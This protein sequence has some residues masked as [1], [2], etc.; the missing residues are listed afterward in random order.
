[1][2]ATPGDH[3]WWLHKVTAQYIAQCAHFSLDKCMLIRYS[4]FGQGDIIT[5]SIPGAQEKAYQ[6]L[7]KKHN[8]AQEKA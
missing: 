2:E 1:M 5:K 3:T 7:R 8:R 4:G 6:G